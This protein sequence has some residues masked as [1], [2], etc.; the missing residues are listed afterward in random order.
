MGVR[1]KVGSPEQSP[2]CPFFSVQ[3]A[4]EA[5]AE[6][7]AAG[8]VAAP[9]AG[10]AEKGGKAKGGEAASAA[11][12]PAAADA[13][14]AAAAA[15]PAS[16]EA[17]ASALR[18]ALAANA[19]GL[20]L[21]ALR[22]PLLPDCPAARPRAAVIARESVDLAG[23]R[24]RVVITRA[25][26]RFPLARGGDAALAA[27]SCGPPAGAPAS[28]SLGDV[29]RLSLA[30][31]DPADVAREAAAGGGFVRVVAGG[32]APASDAAAPQS[33]REGAD[34]FTSTAAWLRAEGGADGGARLRE[35]WAAQ[36]GPEAGDTAAAYATALLA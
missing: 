13:A 26:V 2:L 15:L 23:A 32:A 5:A 29:A 6:A 8:P 35:A 12:A 9:K 1:A 17:A 34:F 7:A 4:A 28:L 20:V 18:A 3:A 24:L 21:A 16:P 14:P 27:V 30:A 10:K 33:L 31:R 25:A 11:A 22:V 36:A 19:G